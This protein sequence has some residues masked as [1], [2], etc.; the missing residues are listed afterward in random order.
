[1]FTQFYP[2]EEYHDNYFALNGEQPYCQMVVRPKVEK[3][4]KAFAELLKS[5]K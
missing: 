3:F 1:P 4:K 2:A 5:Q